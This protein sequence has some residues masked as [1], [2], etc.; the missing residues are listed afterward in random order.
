MNIDQQLLSFLCC[1]FEASD[2]LQKLGAHMCPGVYYLW[3]PVEGISIENRLNHDES[4]SQVLSVEL[5]SVVR[6]L[7]WTVV[8]HLQERR[9]PQVEHELGN[10]TQR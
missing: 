5:M 3:R 1:Q 6:T 9:A 4:L 10:R 7:I 2:I 8:E